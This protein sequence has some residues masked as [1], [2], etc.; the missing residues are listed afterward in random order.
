MSNINE[1]MKSAIDIADQLDRIGHTELAYQIDKQIIEAL[2]QQESW[3]IKM[4]R[5]IAQQDV[6]EVE[7]EIPEEERIMLEDVL[8]S[9]QDSLKDSSKI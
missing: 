7:V 5:V 3:Q 9:L 6:E 2:S 4:R 8:L 1:I